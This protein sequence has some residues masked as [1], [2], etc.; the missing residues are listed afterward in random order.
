MAQTLYQI[1]HPVT[2]MLT[3]D[4]AINV[5]VEHVDII[6]TANIPTANTADQLTT[7]VA[8]SVTSSKPTSQVPSLV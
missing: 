1:G 8:G 6:A 2:N 4:D 3:Q 5:P 7:R